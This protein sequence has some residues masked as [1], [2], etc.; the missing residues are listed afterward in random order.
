MVIFTPSGFD[1]QFADSRVPDARRYWKLYQLRA[2]ALRAMPMHRSAAVDG[3]AWFNVRVDR[4]QQR[5]SLT[6]GRV[7][8]DLG[9]TVT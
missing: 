4:P 8:H 5:V 9:Y 2:G 1:P 6:Q 7:S 3:G